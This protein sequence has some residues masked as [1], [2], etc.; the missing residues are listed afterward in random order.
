MK[1]RK[2]PTSLCRSEA[3]LQIVFSNME[4]D[5]A[6]FLLLQIVQ[7]ILLLAITSILLL[8]VYRKIV[9]PKSGAFK[10]LIVLGSGGHTTEMLSIASSL[11]AP[12]IE[13]ATFLIASTDRMSEIKLRQKFPGAMVKKTPR[14]R[15]VKQSWITSVYTTLIA[16]FH[17]MWF[18]FMIQPDLVLCNGPG[19]CVPIAYSAFLF[20]FFL[21]QRSK[22]IFAESIARVKSLSLSGKL[23]YPIADE[24][25]VQWQE[26]KEKVPRA[27]YVGFLI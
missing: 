15:E 14:A 4:I 13:D 16:S 5:F 21:M 24:F 6:L 8:L 12:L 23:L 25:V 3:H 1:Q 17:A 10:T 9:R 26:L 2:R 22:I 7:I 27:R 11:P 20:R 18:V 19:T